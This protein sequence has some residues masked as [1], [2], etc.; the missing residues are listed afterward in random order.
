MRSF[1]VFIVCLFAN[2]LILVNSAYATTYYVSTNGNDESDGTSVGSAWK[3]VNKVNQATL[4]PGDRV[5]FEAGHTFSGSLQLHNSGTTAQPII[6][7]SYGKGPATISSGNDQGFGAYNVAGIELRRIN[8]MGA[9]RLDNAAVGVYFAVRSADTHLTHLVL[10]SVD[11]CGYQSLG[12]FIAG[13]NGTSGYADVRITNSS[14]HENGD[15]GLYVYAKELGAHRN[16]YV[17]NCKSYDNSGISTITYTNTGSGI[18]LANIDGVL[19]EK[20]EAYNNGWLNVQAGSGPIG[21]WAY[22][23]NNL[24]IQFC[25][26]HHNRTSTIDGGGFDLDGGCTNAIMQYNYSHD[27]QGVGYVLAQ[28][29]GAPPCH[30]VTIRYNISE[31]DARSYAASITLWASGN[32][33][34]IDR[35][36]IYNNTIYVTPSPNKQPVAIWILSSGIRSTAFRN[37]I[38]QTTGGLPFVFDEGGEA[39]FQGNCYWGSGSAGWWRQK[40]SVFQSLADWRTSTGA[41]RIGNTDIGLETDPQ[42]VAPGAGGTNP[43]DLSRSMNAWKPYQLQPTSPMIGAGL[44]LNQFGISPGPRD[45]YGLPTPAAGLRGNIGAYEGSGRPLPVELISFQAEVKSSQASLRWATASERSSAFFEI[46]RSLDGKTFSGVG[47]LAA[48]GTSST[49]RFYQWDDSQRLT[50]ATYYRL[51]QIDLDGSSHYSKVAVVSPNSSAQHAI[52]VFPNPAAK[53]QL[54]YLDLAKFSGQSVQIRVADLMGQTI[55]HQRVAADNTAANVPLQLPAQTS[56]GTYVL[57]VTSGKQTIHAKFI[58]N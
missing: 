23:C 21:I 35:A 47:Q 31:N 8:F 53:G 1:F 16:W 34:G 22:C 37:N 4:Q 28:Y 17:G 27:N 5:L 39:V 42:L 30:D 50:Q 9:G 55:H 38:I 15:T 13:E 49:V 58:I 11:V 26:S 18:T 32:S 41:E 54:L 24:I 19:V 20:C 40:S 44:D 12:I 45:L 7:S 51:R 2:A 46:Q 25:E 10:D 33:S 14:M 43:G 52:S 6:V 36:H 57:S 48:A 3:S 56:P 29:E